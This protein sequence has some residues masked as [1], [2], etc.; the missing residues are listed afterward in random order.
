MG[1]ILQYY[2][3]PP[4]IRNIFFYPPA[5]FQYI[6]SSKHI[7]RLTFCPFALF[8]PYNGI[9]SFLSF[10]IH[11]SPPNDTKRYTPRRGFFAAAKCHY[12]DWLSL[13]LRLELPCSITRCDS[14]NLEKKPA[15][16]WQISSAYNFSLKGKER[17]A[18]LAKRGM[19]G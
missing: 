12:A 6:Y 13:G 19:D 18:R 10:P 11:I 9:L 8:Y 15:N 17:D 7:F 5:I 4:P 14:I 16:S 1:N 3:P 2:A